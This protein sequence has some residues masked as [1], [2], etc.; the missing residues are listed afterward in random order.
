MARCCASPETDARAPTSLDVWL[1]VAQAYALK[2]LRNEEA[3]AATHAP[4]HI[5]L[6]R[7]ATKCLSTGI[8]PRL[9]PGRS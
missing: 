7:N 6:L 8:A 4:R 1:F 3:L 9:T 2:L 5:A